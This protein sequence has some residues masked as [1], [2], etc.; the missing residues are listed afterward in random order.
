MKVGYFTNFASLGV[1]G[2]EIYNLDSS[3][4]NVLGH[5]HLNE[6]GSFSVDGCEFVG[7]DGTPLIDRFTWEKKSS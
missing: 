1:R 6:L 2:K 7:N 4:K 3:D 5:V